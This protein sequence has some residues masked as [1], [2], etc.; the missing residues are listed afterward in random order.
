MVTFFEHNR[1]SHNAKSSVVLIMVVVTKVEIIWEP[2]CNHDFNVFP[3]N[4]WIFK[5]FFLLVFA[6]KML[7]DNTYGLPNPFECKSNHFNS[8]F[9]AEYAFKNSNFGGKYIDDKIS[10][11]F[12]NWIAFSSHCCFDQPQQQWKHD[13]FTISAFWFW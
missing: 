10:C 6:I 1:I 4:I 3:A 7:L 9:Q 13:D 11:W 5:F 8:L 12:W 2:A